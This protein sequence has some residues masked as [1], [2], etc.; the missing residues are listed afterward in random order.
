V[1]RALVRAKVDVLAIEQASGDLADRQAR[2]QRRIELARALTQALAL[3][4]PL[5]ILMQGVSGSGKS[6]LSE[7]L[8]ARVPAVRIRSD[9]ERKRMIALDR[10]DVADDIYSAES[11]RRTYARALDCAEHA[12]SAGFTTIIDATFLQLEDREPFYALAARLHIPHAIVTCNAGYSVLAA[13]IVQ[14]RQMHR[15]ASDADLAVLRHQLDTFQ[16][17]TA[18]ESSQAIT[19]RTDLTDVVETTLQA[20]RE[21]IAR[22]LR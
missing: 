22:F 11:N 13:R 7:R 2:A 10:S 15:D 3:A 5:L 9:V 18:A 12:L 16:P 4:R 20:V 1:Y 14:R 17:L 8:F 19:A 21:R 6:W